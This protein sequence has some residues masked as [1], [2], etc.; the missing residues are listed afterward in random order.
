MPS[1][2]Y[3][4]AVANGVVE[5]KTSRVMELLLNA[6]TPWQL[7]V[8]KIVGIGAA[9]LTQMVCLVAAGIGALLLQIPLQAALFG[10]MSAG[11]LS[12]SLAFRFHSCLLFLVYFLLAYFLYASLFAGLGA[13]VKR[14][15]EVQSAIQ[16][17]LFLLIVS[18]VLLYVAGI[19]AQ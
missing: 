14:Q 9:G 10:A 13:L 7:L 18:L 12:I 2:T 3:A 11:S 1:S 8:G 15:D 4:T 19:C 17:P 6:A 5:E 16:I